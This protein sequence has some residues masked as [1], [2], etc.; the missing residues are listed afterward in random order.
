MKADMTKLK[1]MNYD[2]G[3][4]YL[5]ELGYKNDDSAIDKDAPTCDYIVDYRFT[6]YE[7]KHR[8]EYTQ[9]CNYNNDPAN[10][11]GSKDYVI[12]EYWDEVEC[13][14]EDFE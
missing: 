3:E 10:Y 5:M 2:E 6:N 8:V 4:K 9:F 13:D 14:P 11:D 12:N 7:E 1:K